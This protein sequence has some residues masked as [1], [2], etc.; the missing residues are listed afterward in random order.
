M[1]VHFAEGNFTRLKN[2]YDAL[3]EEHR[4]KCREFAQLKNA[5]DF[6]NRELND[7]L[8]TTS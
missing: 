5:V 6:A 1:A 8:G 3:A 4:N 7:V 2:D